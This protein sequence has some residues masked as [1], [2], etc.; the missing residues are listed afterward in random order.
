MWFCDGA[1]SLLYRLQGVDFEYQ[2]TL[3]AIVAV[4]ASTFTRVINTIFF[5][6]FLSSLI[7][8]ILLTLSLSYTP[9][10]HCLLTILFSNIAS[11]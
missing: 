1:P 11:L 6:R 2:S 3:G 4:Y 10:L 8:I 5:T 9:T 7:S